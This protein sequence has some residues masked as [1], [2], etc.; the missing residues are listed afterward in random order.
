MDKF[1]YVICRVKI[2]D[3]YYLLDASNKNVGFGKLPEKAY[4]GSVRIIDEMPVL[5]DLSPDSLKESKI[6]TVFMTDDNNSILG[7]LSSQYGSFKSAEMRDELSKMTA[8]DYLK[9][10]KKEYSFDGNLSNIEI[11]SLKIPEEPLS[12]KYDMDFKFSD[13]VVYFSPILAE[14]VKEN[15]FKAAERF[16][17]VEMSACTD[18]T[19]ILNME[20]PKGY[21]VDELPKSARVSLNENEGMFEYII[22]ESGGVSSSDVALKLRKQPLRLKII[23][24]SEIFFLSL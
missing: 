13:D 18:E 12:V 7:S 9:E 4:N 2:G 22:A 14:A 24:H 6:I 23:K 20:V 11:D 16:F 5:V 1:N 8:S 10:L 17:P 15:P 3:D 19:Y 21:K